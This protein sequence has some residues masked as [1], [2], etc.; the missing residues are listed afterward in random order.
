MEST[1]AKN[2]TYFN[3]YVIELDKKYL[4]T[5]TYHFIRLIEQECW[6][7]KLRVY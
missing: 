7:K 1:F 3:P 2:Q 4:L 5:I 6:N